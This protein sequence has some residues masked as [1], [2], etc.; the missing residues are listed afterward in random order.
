MIGTTLLVVYL[1][2]GWYLEVR[3]WCIPFLNR[4]GVSLCLEVCLHREI[5]VGVLGF[6]VVSLLDVP[7]LVANTSMGE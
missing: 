7:S 3:G 5:V 4:G 6:S 2:L 1:S